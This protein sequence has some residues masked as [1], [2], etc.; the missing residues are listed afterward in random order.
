MLYYQ[1]LNKIKLSETFAVLSSS[2]PGKV[3]TRRRGRDS[4]GAVNAYIPEMLGNMF[5][6]AQCTTPCICCCHQGKQVQ[7]VW[8]HKCIIR[9]SACQ[10]VP[11]DFD[12]ELLPPPPPLQCSS[13]RMA[14]H[15]SR[16]VT[17]PPWQNQSRQHSW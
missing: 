3:L 16:K 9:Q 1:K 15:H 17:F 12:L 13:C 5:L 10:T 11:L 6:Y 7:Q 8:A 4:H 2:N 14:E